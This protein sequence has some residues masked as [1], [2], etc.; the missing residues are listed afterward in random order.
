MLT[1]FAPQ[2]TTDTRDADSLYPD[3]AALDDS[4]LIGALCNG[5]KVDG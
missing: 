4:D 1:A 2:F 5:N 3:F